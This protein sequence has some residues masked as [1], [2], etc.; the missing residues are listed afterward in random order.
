[1]E[2]AERY[3]AWPEGYTGEVFSDLV[4]PCVCHPKGR[5]G[6]AREAELSKAYCRKSK[7]EVIVFSL[8]L[9]LYR[10]ECTL[11]SSH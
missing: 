6:A 2:S 5:R 3:R 1:M 10:Y 9:C 11:L 4:R 8:H 7:G